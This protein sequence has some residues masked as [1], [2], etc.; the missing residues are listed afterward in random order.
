LSI[1]EFLAE[2]AT[3]SS[4]KVVALP[5]YLLA[6]AQEELGALAEM[7]RPARPPRDAYCLGHALLDEAIG[8]CDRH[9]IWLDDSVANGLGRAIR[10]LRARIGGPSGDW[11]AD[12][13]TVASLACLSGFLHFHASWEHHPLFPG[14][15]ACLATQG[16]SLQGLSLFAAAYCLAVHGAHVSFPIE[17]GAP[18]M[19]DH[20]SLADGPAQSVVVHVCNLGAIGAAGIWGSDTLYRDVE[21]QVATVFPA[22]SACRRGMLVLFGGVAVRGLEHE[23]IESVKRALHA[24]GRR[25]PNLMAVASLV[26]NVRIA[27]DGVDL[28]LDYGF[29]PIA[30]GHLGSTDSSKPWRNTSPGRMLRSSG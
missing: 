24:H 22:V 17:A 15:L 28:Y 19:L 23:L 20:F 30:N 29:I 11:H 16:F 1:F 13:E 3:E 12:P 9:R 6:A 8:I 18:T 10:H 4:E 7:H 21:A 14:M 27:Q 5:A 2:R 26:F 25:N